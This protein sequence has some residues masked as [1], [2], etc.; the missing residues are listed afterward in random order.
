MNKQQRFTILIGCLIIAAMSLFP[1]Y[2]GVTLRSRTLSKIVPEDTL[3]R[4]VGYHFICIPPSPGIV[5]EKLYGRLSEQSKTF[6][7][8][9]YTSHLDLE[10]L[11]VQMVAVILITCGL[12]VVF[13]R[14]KKPE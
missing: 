10:R 5:Y 14:R 9:N 4:F 8:N 12:A 6:S 7:K 1:P 11:A 3:T 2:Q 13:Q